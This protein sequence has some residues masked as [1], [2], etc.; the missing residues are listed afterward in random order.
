MSTQNYFQACQ[1]L[2]AA[3][4]LY[5][6]L[7]QQYHPDHAGE[8]E[9]ETA[10]KVVTDFADFAAGK[11]KVRFTEWAN[12]RRSANKYAPDYSDFTPFGKILAQLC[13]LDAAIDIQIV[14]YWIYVRGDT[15]PI[16]DYLS[17]LGCFW[18]QTYKAWIYNG[19]KK[20]P[21]GRAFGN[22]YELYDAIDVDKSASEKQRKIA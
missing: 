13:A 16:K 22:A 7:L 5:R 15:K 3:K 6:E 17:G 11:V 8:A 14:G 4:K 10:K 20:K 2:E 18:S 12:E 19:G 9:L 1:T 21:K